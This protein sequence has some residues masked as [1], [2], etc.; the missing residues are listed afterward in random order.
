VLRQS[1]EIV[2][3]RA[4]LASS[5]IEPPAGAVPH[6]G[7]KKKAFAAA[8][9]LPAPDHDPYANFRQLPTDADLELAGLFQPQPER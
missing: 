4:M 7:L 2:N 9:A 6:G 1:Q 8:V 3:L 5:S